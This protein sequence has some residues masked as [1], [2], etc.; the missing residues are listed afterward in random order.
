[1]QRTTFMA[2]AQNGQVAVAGNPFK[3][4]ELMGMLDPFPTM[5]P[6]VEPRPAR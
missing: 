5:F 4:M 6:L 1:M 3:L 2:A